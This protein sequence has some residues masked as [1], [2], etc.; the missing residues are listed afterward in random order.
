M[1]LD[2]EGSPMLQ[3]IPTPKRMRIANTLHTNCGGYILVLPRRDCPFGHVMYAA[4]GRIRGVM[5]RAAVATIV[6]ISLFI[7]CFLFVAEFL[8]S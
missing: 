5:T 1:S 3:A 2:A 6:A 8:L 4:I 7:L